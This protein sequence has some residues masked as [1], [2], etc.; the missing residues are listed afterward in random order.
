MEQLE[1][2]Q[3]LLRRRLEGGDIQG[4]LLGAFGAV[5]MHQLQV[6]RVLVEEGPLTMKDLASRIGIGPSSVTQLVDRLT[7]HGLVERA[8][9]PKD[10]RIQRIV[11]TQKATEA[12][13]NFKASKRRQMRVLLDPLTDEELETFVSLA[14]RMLS[15]LCKTKVT[16]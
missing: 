12:V 11:V 14:E 7:Q 1:R 9:D 15:P 13:T 4:S 6:L 3:P 2:L 8:S 16:T 10:R 5:T